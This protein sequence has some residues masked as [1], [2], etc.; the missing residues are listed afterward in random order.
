M[1]PTNNLYYKTLSE[2]TLK[3]P[4][5][6]TIKWLPRITWLFLINQI[7]FQKKCIN[8][9]CVLVNKHIVTLLLVGK[10]KLQSRMSKTTIKGFLKAL[11]VNDRRSSLIV[12]RL[13]YPHLLKC[14]KRCKD[15]TTNP[16]RIFALRRGYDLYFHCT[17]SYKNMKWKRY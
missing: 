8:A 15:W 16:N 17:W 5:L 9:N 13:W 14:R 11:S 7:F 10:V 3:H 2:S 12:L 4:L 1:S 6:I